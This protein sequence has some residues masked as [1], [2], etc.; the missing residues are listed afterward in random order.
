MKTQ[1]EIEQEIHEH[2]KR[3][4]AGSQHAVLAYARS[5]TAPGVADEAVSA[6]LA[7]FAGL[8]DAADLDTMTDA[9]EAACEQVNFDEW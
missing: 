3:L 2:L 4:P 1:R 5:L 8:I 6:K 9:I 7:R